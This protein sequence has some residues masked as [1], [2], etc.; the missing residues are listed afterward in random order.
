MARK[1]ARRI[2]LKRLAYAGVGIVAAGCDRDR[3]SHQPPQTLAS[4]A[5]RPPERVRCDDSADLSKEDIERRRGLA[6]T[7]R[8]PDPARSCGNCQHLQPVPGSDTPCKRCSVIAGPVHVHGWCSA[9]T[10]R[11][12]TAPS[13][14]AHVD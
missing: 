13:R 3:P 7:D 8:A 12:A 14:A 4:Q 10:E 5:A 2:F 9:W 11:A 6:Y 1:A